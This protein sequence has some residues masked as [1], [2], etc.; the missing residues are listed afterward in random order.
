[1]RT[2]R[3]AI[4]LVLTLPTAAFAAIRGNV[5]TSE[6]AA[7]TATKIAAYRQESWSETAAR[8]LSA[9]PD[10]VPLALAE[11]DAKGSFTI[12]AKQTTP[13]RLVFSKHGFAPVA[14][15]AQPDDDIGAVLL[16]SAAMKKGRVTAGG[17]PLA[18]TLVVWGLRN[19]I[20][21]ATRTSE[22]G[23]YNVPDPK[24]WGTDVFVRAEGFAPLFKTIVSPAPADTAVILTAGKSITGKVAGSDGVGVAKAA[25]LVDG[26]PLGVTAEDGSFAI[27]HVPDDSRQLVASTGDRIGVMDRAR[28]PKVI[29]LAK[30]S[31]LQVCATDAKTRKPLPG[32]S[33]NLVLGTM[34]FRLAPDIR[35]YVADTKGC[36]AITPLLAGEYEV[37][38]SSPGYSTASIDVPLRAG[39]ASR[40]AVVAAPM[41]TVAGVV[42]DDV[43]QPVGAARVSPRGTDR[44]A[45]RMGPD[46]AA[47]SGADGR[48][49]LRISPERDLVI[50]A[51]RKG[52]PDSNEVRMTLAPA[53]KRSGVALVIPR[54]LRVAGKVTDGNGTAL[55]GVSIASEAAS[56]GGFGGRIMIR[57]G[58][59][60]DEAER[61]TTA[62]DG[63]FEIRLKEGKYDLTFQRE[64]LASKVLR[65][66][67][68]SPQTEPLA[69]VLDPGVAI[70]GRVIRTTGEGVADAIVLVVGE[71]T[72]APVRSAPDGSFEVPDLTPG[73]K[74]LIVN[75]PDEFIR[76]NRSV[77]AP[78]SNVEIRIAPGVTVSGRVIDKESQAPITD[79]QA[80]ISNSRSGGGRVMVA[81]PSLREF[82]SGDGTFVL[83]HLPVGVQ[84]L[85]VSAPGYVT[86]HL[87]GMSLE[88]GKPLTDLEVALESGVRLTGKVTGPDGT[89]LSGVSVALD[90]PTNLPVRAFMMNDGVVTDG[91]GEYTIDS[92]E[93][94]EK[95]FTF[96]KSGYI[97]E[98]RTLTLSG[99]EARLDVRLSKG[100][101][102]T[103]VVTNDAGA[104][105]GG[106]RVHAS[107]A[108]RDAAYD[109]AETD[110]NGAFSFEGL[111]PGR[112]RFSAS[113]A[114][115]SPGVVSD[116]DIATAGMVRVIL[117]TGG[118]ISGH[119][120][121]LTPQEL[122]QVSVMVN[123]EPVSAPVDSSGA[124]RAEGIEP[125]TV[126][127]SASIRT[128]T[129][130]KN[131]PSKT[132]EV[133]A[134]SESTVDLEFRSDVV[135]RGRVT[136]DDAPA[137]N[138]QVM[139]RP[140]D[141][142]IETNSSARTDSEGNYEVSGLENGAYTV[143]VFNMGTFTSF[144]TSY[145]VTGSGRFDI[146]IRGAAVRGQVSDGDTGEAIAGARVDLTSAAG[147][148]RAFGPSSMSDQSGNFTVDGVTPGD[149]R[150]RAQKDGYG[151]QIIDATVS[152]IGVDGLSLKLYKTDGLALRVVDARDNRALDA[153]FR[154][155]DA[156]G[157]E[158]FRG[159][160]NARADGT[161][162]IPVSAGAYP[163][164]I[165][166]SGYAMRSVTANAPSAAVT[167]GMTPGGVLVVDS[168]AAA[169]VRIRI[170]DPQGQNVSQT[171]W[172]DDAMTV[173]PGRNEVARLAPG[174][175]TI[176]VLGDDGQVKTSKQVTMVEGQPTEVGI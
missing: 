72:E 66:V 56:G 140:D 126:N 128:F 98:H 120:I 41:A 74:M 52:F 82:H 123:D 43:K 23:E 10:A 29:Q 122:T 61:V 143:D 73:T 172:S 165:S 81:S 87:P 71:P 171:F 148:S 134:G 24:R 160:G 12:D 106:A 159:F 48:F 150:V 147:T 121:G 1:M 65:A 104:S 32:M 18:N 162:V 50:R 38:V 129:G 13:V 67:D 167:I 19:G 111:A 114:G 35:R 133:S 92:I 11:S 176:D 84:E 132:V 96:S 53:E 4:A 116:V 70:R 15:T 99:R 68:V 101:R 16:R 22:K 97:T 83:D 57:M 112:Y 153:F 21:Y 39:E 8:L 95:S 36:V 119:I 37:N 139:F 130:G 146:D 90:E 138:V 60:D 125:G 34:R 17:A 166:T 173:S 151:Q 118:I 105:I 20:E 26:W 131:S 9:A 113:K 75:K 135:I 115:Y 137:A 28:P 64:G 145:T 30:A 49:V 14:I 93:P 91:S 85:L 63:T 88:E 59:R 86:K 155:R 175:Y 107:S 127:V 7:A 27:E 100:M 6:G 76:E 149:Y 5:V 54:G 80:G 69:V 33:V 62:S 94:A 78:A 89:P 168:S 152:D 31:S 40:R 102:V 136:K 144:H 47:W 55:S 79:F 124:Y 46:P 163:V 103:G 77:D 117:K 108:A 25:I 141:A 3:I 42:D 156:Q 45:M 158:A 142:K 174:I 2:C 170:T 164:T 51:A 44:R 58:P 109:Q 154:L 161:V 157:R 169:P 110:D